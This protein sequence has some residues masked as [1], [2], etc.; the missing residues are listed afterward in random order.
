M[1]S[2]FSVFFYFFKVCAEIG[3]NEQSLLNIVYW[4]N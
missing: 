1:F 2:I 4:G 3:L